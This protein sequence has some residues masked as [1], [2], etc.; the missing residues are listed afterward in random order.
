MA[1]HPIPATSPVRR[2]I[3]CP[4][5]CWLWTAY[6]GGDLI[7]RWVQ[8]RR[9]LTLDAAP[10]RAVVH[11]TADTRY[12]LFVNGEA[13]NEG[14]ARGFQDAWPYDSVDITPWLVAGENVIAAIAYNY[15]IGTHSYVH[16]GYAGFILWGEVDGQPIHSDRT[17]KVRDCP[18]HLRHQTQ[19]SMQQDWQEFVDGR[20]W[21]GDWTRAGYDDSHWPPASYFGARAMGSPPWHAL[22]PRDIPLLRRTVLAPARL[23]ATANG[24]AL[25]EAA[26]ATDVV[27]CFDETALTWTAVG[28]PWQDDWFSVPASAGTIAYA[29]D[30]GREMV[31]SALI[32]VRGAIGGEVIDALWTEWCEGAQPVFHRGHAGFGHRYFCRPGDQTDESFQPWGCRHLVLVVRGAAQGLSLRLRMRD[33]VYPVERRGRMASSDPLVARIFEMCAHTQEATMTDAYNDPFREKGMWWGDA[34]CHFDNSQRLMADDRLFVRG[35]R[36]IGRQTLPNGLTYALAPTKSHEC[37]LP[38]F[39]LMWIETLHQHYWYSGSPA[40]FGEHVDKVLHALDYFAGEAAATGLLWLDWRYWLFLDWSAPHKDGCPTLYNLQY[41]RTL[42]LAASMLSIIGHRRASE[43]QARAV[44]LRTVI[45]ERLWDAER[46]LPLDGLDWEGRPVPAE[47]LHNRVMAIRN[48]VWPEH[49]RGWIEGDL[50]PFLAGPRPRGDRLYEDLDPTADR[51]ALTPYFMQFAY[52]VLEHAG[53]GA[54]VVGNIQ[55]WWGDMLERGLITTEE[56]WNARPGIGSLCHA[57]ASHP[58]Q[59]LPATLL[60]I[61]QTAPNWDAVRLAPVFVGDHADGAIDT[62]HGVLAVAWQRTAGGVD[63]RWSLPPGMRAC[64]VLAGEEREAVGSGCWS[65]GLAATQ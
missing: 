52:E 43:V 64:I 36:L 11:V 33:A 61:R 57:W 45:S 24:P 25:A 40:L 17:W 31:A 14:P 5:A 19:T 7:N 58:I 41:L 56:A 8:V 44:A 32:E 13:V 22:V 65:S 35:L 38:D 12:R 20:R 34:H 9:V 27:R 42:E 47:S 6:P 15:G 2:D 29:L 18:Q 21:D 60:G 54:A 28:Q 3:A 53:H 51:H 55:R 1:I 46:G 48:G 59:H 39:T 30:F 62:P 26:A 37:V 16:Q 63:L 4:Q 23:H 50:L 49:H 10:T